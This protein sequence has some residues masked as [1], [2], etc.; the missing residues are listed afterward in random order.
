M[1]CKR[2]NDDAF[3]GGRISPKKR[4]RSGDYAGDVALD[5]FPNCP[6]AGP[7]HTVTAVHTALHALASIKEHTSANSTGAAA[8]PTASN[9]G[10][11]P[12][13]AAAAAAGPA[14]T[15]I[16]YAPSAI[17]IFNYPPD[18]ETS[19]DSRSLSPPQVHLHPP[20]PSPVRQQQL[21]E[22]LWKEELDSICR[23]QPLMDT[24]TAEIITCNPKLRPATPS[25]VPVGGASPPPAAELMAYDEDL[26]RLDL[27]AD[28]IEIQ[29]EEEVVL[30]E[31]SNTE[32]GRD[33]EPQPERPRTPDRPE[34]YGLGAAEAR[35]GV[36]GDCLRYQVLGGNA[37]P[38]PAPQSGP[39]L[40]LEDYLHQ[41]GA[42]DDDDTHYRVALVEDV[43]FAVLRNHGPG[44]ARRRGLLLA[45]AGGGAYNSRHVFLLFA[46]GNHFPP[47]NPNRHLGFEFRYPAPRSG[48]R[49]GPAACPARLWLRWYGF[50]AVDD[51]MISRENC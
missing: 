40:R 18:T 51:D 50:G 21:A 31:E 36:A 34:F 33:C 25:L 6:A 41:L 29:P 9:A 19:S 38:I 12:A 15:P 17:A 49:P 27:K 10:S 30:N 16:A 3:P 42:D 4:A 13:A 23:E 39:R 48:P 26:S 37:G 35:Q 28:M 24:S 1:S 45:R 14:T 46:D 7:D 32:N 43:E 22:A 44:P 8:P 11:E 2:R 20:L 5:L 47:M